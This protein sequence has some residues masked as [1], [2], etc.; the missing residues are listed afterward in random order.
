MSIKA[1]REGSGGAAKTSNHIEKEHEREERESGS[2]VYQ[3]F[4]IVRNNTLQV[5]S[6]EGARANGYF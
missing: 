5:N 3:E 2:V 6:R 4:H 1:R